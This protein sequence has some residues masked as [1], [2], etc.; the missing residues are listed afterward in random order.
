MGRV[1]SGRSPSL[2]PPC[3]R[4]R[5]AAVRTV[6]DAEAVAGIRSGQRVYV[7]AAS[8]VPS[9]LLDA[10]CARADELEDVR[11][12]HLHVEGPGPHLAPEMQGHFQHEALFIGP[13]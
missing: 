11:V 1:S 9:V 2:V 5:L 10:L 6:T 4:H 8:A 12:T 7:Q 13:N 3:P